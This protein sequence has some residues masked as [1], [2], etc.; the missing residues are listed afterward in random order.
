[1]EL[2]SLILYGGVNVAM[3][4]FYL[5]GKGRFYQFPFWAGMIAL[6]WFFPQ[7]VG[8]YVHHRE[9]PENSY[10]DAMFFATLCTVALWI[11]FELAAKRSLTK[12]SW[13]DMPF[14]SQRLYY[15]GAA[16][17]TIGFFF[18]WKLWSLPEEMLAQ[19]QWS[20]ATVKYL[21]LSNVFKIGFLSLW[22]LYLS[23]PRVF[24]PKLLVFIAP[25]M[26]LFFEAAVLRGRRAGMMDLV[27]YLFVCLWFVRRVSLPRWILISGLSIGLILINGIHT[28]RVIL[29]NKDAPLSERLSEAANADYIATSKQNWNESGAEFKNYLY[30]RHIHT[31]MKLYDYG[32]VHWNRFVRNYIPAQVIGRSFKDSLVLSPNDLDIKF[33]VE[34]KYSHKFKLGTTM[35][36][37]KDSAG[38]FGWFGFIKF[39]LI[40]SIMGVLYRHAMQG[41]FLGQLLYVYFLTDGM[42]CISHATDEF[43]VRGWIYFFTLGYP[44]LLWAKAKNRLPHLDRMGAVENDNGR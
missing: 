2:F 6:G 18:Q 30:Y 5:S 42:Q 11:G 33:L 21:F 32:I 24:A 36:G 13:L 19:S 28:Y 26:L 14:D 35:T 25:C 22:L 8:G 41:A 34:E 29:M 9:F 20:G 10:M 15:A 40:G 39:L 43:L 1:M 3:V 12:A 27:S 17:C 23:Q 38:S 4:F 16:L 37:Y 7:A 44:A 31:E